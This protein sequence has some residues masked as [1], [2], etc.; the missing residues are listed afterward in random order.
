MVVFDT[1]RADAFE[2]YGAGAGST[3]VFAELAARG[4]AP[5]VAVAPSNWT[6]PSHAS[7]FTGL[8]PGTLGL[9][10]PVGHRSETGLASR[11][12]LEERADRVLAE[13][14]RR[15]GYR[16]AA[17]SCNPWIHP[18]HGFATGFETFE[19]V[20]GGARRF[21]T[22]S[23]RSELRWA[24]DA[25]RARTDDGARRAE[26][27]LRRWTAEADGPFFWFVNL[28]ECHSP[29]LPPRPYGRLGGAQRVLAARDAARYQTPEGLHRVCVGELHPS[30]RSLTRM[31]HLYAESVRLMDD[32]LGRILAVLDD[33]GLLDDTVVVVTSDH[34]E[35]LGECHLMGHTLS[36]ADRLLR[37]P[38]AFAGPDRVEVDGFAS[39]VDVPRVV[40]GAVGLDDHPWHERELPDGIAVSQ[41]G[42]QVLLPE[43]EAL[44]RGWGVP[45]EAIRLI[46]RP[47]DCATDGRWKVVRD[48]DG[49]HV[50]D[51]VGD[52]LEAAPVPAGAVPAE[53]GGS[54][55]ALTA[56]LDAAERRVPAPPATAVPA[57]DA[58]DDLEARMREL[59]YL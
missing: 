4:T 13:V 37:V 8:L 26:Q 42:A 57:P 22:G 31:R 41:V 40:A 19:T 25:W 35:N 3:P 50:Y 36:M 38:L 59:G 52:P 53:A 5:E 51:L 23:L 14:L 9:S 45:E 44:A 2:P 6:L 54:V 16:T 33:R 29:L 49:D 43:K 17:V 20:R 32:W 12:M 58:D 1:A 39:L 56:A 46:A 10:S 34:G 55:A 24:L 15:A 47:M 28:M 21:P 7:M 27:I 30:E 18:A 48:P 11:Q